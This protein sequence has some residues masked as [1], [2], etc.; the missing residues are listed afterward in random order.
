VALLQCLTF[1]F[2]D[3]FPAGDLSLAPE[4]PMVPMIA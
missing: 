1:T 3:K 4:P 2:I